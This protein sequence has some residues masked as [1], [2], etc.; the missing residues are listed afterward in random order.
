LPHRI[1]NLSI[2]VPLSTLLR[3]IRPLQDIE[4]VTIKSWFKHDSGESGPHPVSAPA[5]AAG[6]GSNGA[7]NT[8][9]KQIQRSLEA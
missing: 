9:A 8:V 6:G 4:V 3:G 1:P 7:T 5:A 2:E